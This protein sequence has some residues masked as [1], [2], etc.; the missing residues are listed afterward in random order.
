MYVRKEKIKS[1]TVKQNKRKTTT[2]KMKKRTQNRGKQT[3]HHKVYKQKKKLCRDRDQK[4][5][6]LYWVRKCTSIK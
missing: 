3:K 5:F 6:L 2:C 1:T 4:W